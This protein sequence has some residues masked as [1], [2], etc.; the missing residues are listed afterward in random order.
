MFTPK[1]LF[2]NIFLNHRRDRSPQ[3]AGR[4]EE[5]ELRL[6]QADA[7][8]QGE[9][10]SRHR[11]GGQQPHSGRGQHQQAPRELHGD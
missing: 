9:R 1:I 6:G 4:R 5:G 8:T 7:Q 10:D 11:G 2:L 3:W